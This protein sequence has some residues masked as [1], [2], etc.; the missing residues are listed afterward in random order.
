MESKDKSIVLIGAGIM[1]ATLGIILHKLFPKS[2]ITII[3]RMDRVAAESSDAWNNAGT[4]HSAFCELNYTPEDENGNVDISKALSIAEQFEI[5]KQFW[6]Y[7]VNDLNIGEDPSSFINNIDHLSF[8]WGEENVEFLKKRYSALKEHA[9]FEDMKFTEDSEQIKKWTPLLF[10]HRQDY[11]PKAATK[12]DFGTDVNF[13]SIT[14]SMIEYLSKFENIKLLLDTEVD[15]ICRSNQAWKIEVKN[16]TTK[17]SNKI[18]A[19]FVFIGAGGGSLSLLEKSNIPEAKGFGGFP[20]GGLWLRCTNEKVINQH[21]AK[22]YGKAE[23]GAPP[24]SVPH[25][26]TR[27]INGE[28]ALL[29]G[30]YAGFSTKF[31]KNGSYLDLF[32]SIEMHNVWPMLSAGFN[33]VPLTKYLIEQVTQSKDDKIEALKKFVPSAKSDDWEEIVAGQRVQIIKK[34]NGVGVLKFGTEVVCSEDGT[35]ATLL[36]ASPGASTAVSIM[37]DVVEKCF[38]EQF[39]SDEWQKIFKEMIPSFGVSLIENRA[40]LH[41]VRKESAKALKLDH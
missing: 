12:M 6:A 15:D 37:I 10:D 13:G 26:D 34:E 4:G 11:F 41:K 2:Q 39:H 28:R 24:M 22:V 20:V 14:K 27:I 36:G 35:L 31:L 3:E 1:S 32:L 5:S 38:P 23:V 33:N 16:L 7:L 21:F 9:I 30:P 40:I 8:V 25:L 19:D 29:F 17:E 18:E